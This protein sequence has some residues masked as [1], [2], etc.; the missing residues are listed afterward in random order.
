MSWLDDLLGKVI[1]L[2]GSELPQRK[3]LNF[4]Q[5]ASATVS[6]VDNTSLGSTDVTIDGGAAAAT[7]VVNQSPGAS[8]NGTR[9]NN[10]GASG[11]I[12]INLPAAPATGYTLSAR[13]SDAHYIKFKANTGQT[14]RMDSMISASAGYV[15]STYVGAYLTVEWL[16]TLWFVSALG[17]TW[18]KDE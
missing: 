3:N 14:I 1:M 15:R 12:V 6:V 8:A 4:I 16:G 13:V 17:G 5:G 9:Y 2:G 18:L 11:D 7:V 10:H